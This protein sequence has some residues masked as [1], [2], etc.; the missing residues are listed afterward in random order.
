MAGNSPD[1]WTTLG[2]HDIPEHTLLVRSACFNAAAR[3]YAGLPRPPWEK[4]HALWGAL[5]DGYATT[6]AGEAVFVGENGDLLW[7][8]LTETDHYGWSP[9]KQEVRWRGGTNQL[10]GD[11]IV[12]AALYDETAAQQVTTVLLAGVGHDNRADT[13][14]NVLY[15]FLQALHPADGDECRWTPEQQDRIRGF[16]NMVEALKP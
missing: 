3:A 6:S 4:S 16:I 10:D 14:E 7:R 13:Q 15:I 8:V 1:W 9:L 2:G 5:P 11:V 12:A